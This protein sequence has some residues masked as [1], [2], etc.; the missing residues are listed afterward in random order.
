VIATKLT[1]KRRKLVGARLF[2]LEVSGI[3]QNKFCQNLKILHQGPVFATEIVAQLGNDLKCSSCK[4][5]T[6]EEAIS[7]FTLLLACEGFYLLAL[8]FGPVHN[9]LLW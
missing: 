1:A 2:T 4:R 7:F 5:V 9:I 6:L 3:W 8:S